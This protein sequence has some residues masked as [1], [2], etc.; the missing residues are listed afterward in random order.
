LNTRGPGEPFFKTYYQAWNSMLRDRPRP[1]D[2]IRDRAAAGAFWNLEE[3]QAAFDG[4]ERLVDDP[5][6]GL[7]VRQRVGYRKYL[8]NQTGEQKSREDRQERMGQHLRD[9]W[10]FYF[11]LLPLSCLTFVVV[12]SSQ[13]YTNAIRT[14]IL[15]FAMFGFGG[16]LIYRVIQGTPSNEA[17]EPK[18]QAPKVPKA[19]EKDDK[20]LSA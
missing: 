19:E 20:S 7:E 13:S 2:M 12:V 9:F 15:L 10:W 14:L 4:L 11:V 6:V 3:I 16:W 5:V 18:K 1:S 17:S 8:Q